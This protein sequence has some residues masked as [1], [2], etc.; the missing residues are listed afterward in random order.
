MWARGA[1]ILIKQ[2]KLTSLTRTRFSVVSDVETDGNLIKFPDQ[3]PHFLGSCLTLLRGAIQSFKYPLGLVYDAKIW[4][5]SASPL[6]MSGR[7][8]SHERRDPLKAP[9]PLLGECIL[10]DM[11]R[12]RLRI[13]SAEALTHLPIALAIVFDGFAAGPIVDP[14]RHNDKRGMKPG[15]FGD[16]EVSAESSR[17]Q[18]DIAWLRRVIGVDEEVMEFV[19]AI[20]FR[21]VD[22]GESLGTMLFGQQDG[23]EVFITL[24][25]PCPPRVHSFNLTTN[26]LHILARARHEDIVYESSLLQY[27]PLAFF[28]TFG[29]PRY[30]VED[31]V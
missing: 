29:E 7:H 8:N 3:I 23:N 28:S 22:A 2:K 31:R 9:T 20:P 26:K 15:G 21:S 16:V 12:P 19:G 24:A 17:N 27:E 30:E 11:L 6:F 5:V 18:G 14:R 25:L 4:R 13:K 1:L 10:G